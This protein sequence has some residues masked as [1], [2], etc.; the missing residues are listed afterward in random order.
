MISFTDIDVQQ[1][2]SDFLFRKPNIGLL[3][4]VVDGLKGEN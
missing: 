1:L 4:F 2:I 3:E